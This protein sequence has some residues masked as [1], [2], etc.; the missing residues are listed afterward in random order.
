MFALERR[1]L[2]PPDLDDLEP[3]PELSE[4]LLGVDIDL[5]TPDDRVTV[6]RAL[7][8]MAA[9][10]AA[11]RYRAMVAVTDAMEAP[12][13]RGRLEAAEAEIGAA[14]HLT[15]RAASVELMTAWDLHHRHPQVR[16]ALHAGHIDVRRAR[17]LID[18]TAH[19]N[20]AAAR[21]V[22]AEVIDDAATLTTGQLK[23]LVRRVCTETHPD[24]AK[25]RYNRSVEDRR[26]VMEPT[27]NGTAD[28]LGLDFPPAKLAAGMRRVNT[29]ARSLKTADEPRT[30]DQL[31]ADVVCDLLMGTGVAGRAGR[32]TVDIRVD[33]E[34]LAEL[35]DAPGDLAGY[36]PVI[37]DIARQVADA[38]RD[39]EWRIVITDPETGDPIHVATTGYRPTAQQR[40]TVE[41]LYRT[42]VFP[43]CR[44]PARDSDLDHRRPHASSGP[45]TVGNLAPLCRHHH[46]IRHRYGWKY[47]RKPNGDHHWTSPLGHHYTVSRDPP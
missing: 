7:D 44:M 25:D 1:E 20:D 39:S 13:Q 27:H 9:H 46:G 8:R 40:R 42:C 37:A 16:Q 31:R 29:L 45:T 28:L 11:L 21:T 36:G 26:V 41:A 2:I 12:D 5:L 3:G 18:G 23:A 6:L 35:S 43:G 38:Q 14:L 24:D 47:E 19:L 17:T 10:I 4:L 34:T 33:L 15:R 32:G 30:M 22:V